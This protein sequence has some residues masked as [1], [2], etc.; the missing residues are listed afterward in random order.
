[1]R[2]TNHTK[3]RRMLLGL[4]AVIILVGIVFLPGK[5]GAVSVLLRYLRIRKKIE[6][7]TRYQTTLD[8]LEQLQKLLADPDYAK[9]LARFRLGCIPTD[10]IGE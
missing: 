7:R 6:Q 2:N 9:K 1:M 3:R 10:S 5:S 4:G 8:S